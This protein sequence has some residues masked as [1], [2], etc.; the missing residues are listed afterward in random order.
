MT[1]LKSKALIAGFTEAKRIGVQ[2]DLNVLL[3]ALGMK[4]RE[5]RYKPDSTV[6]SVLVKADFTEGPA[7][8]VAWFT[9]GTADITFH[10]GEFMRLHPD[11]TPEQL[12]SSLQNSPNAMRMLASA[13]NMPSSISK[14]DFKIAREIAGLLIHE[15]GHALF[16]TWADIKISAK[17]SVIHT[18]VLFEEG[19][20][21][22]RVVDRRNE[23]QPKF[24]VK[25]Y[26]RSLARLLLG[27][28]DLTFPNMHSMLGTWSLVKSR[29]LA[30]TLSMDEFAPIDN[31]VRSHVGDELM[32]MLSDIYEE[33]MTVKAPKDLDR[34]MELAT[35][36]EDLITEASGEEPGV[37][38]HGTGCSHLVEE[39][40]GEE[41][42]GGEGEEGD[43]G[44]EESDGKSESGKSG[45]E[46]GKGGPGEPGSD[47]PNTD[48]KPVKEEDEGEFVDVETLPIVEGEANTS[49]LG[50]DA[51]AAVRK[52]VVGLVE[53]AEWEKPMIDSDLT[54][55]RD[56]A[57]TFL[58]RPNYSSGRWVVR[59]PTSIE[60]TAANKLA[61]HLE[62]LMVPTIGQ[63]KVLTE[64]PTG[65]LK[66]R[67]AVR[68]SAERSQGRMSTAKPW[69]DKR[70][71]HTLGA[72]AI[73]GIATDTSGSM[74]WAQAMVASAA[75]IIGHAGHRINAKTA[76]VTFGSAV[77]AVLAPGEVPSV[78]RERAADGGTEELDQALA[79][80]D[81]ALGLTSNPGAAKVL[82]IISDNEL[83]KPFEH[84][85]REAWLEKLSKAG[86]TIIW[87]DQAK[88]NVPHTTS[89]SFEWTSISRE[90]LPLKL[91]ETISKALDKAMGRGYA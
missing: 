10:V 82:V 64:K 31:A 18:M 19:R 50:P 45:G 37:G 35:E 77:E 57:N 85:K 44:G 76:A 67:E 1:A 84:A 6:A 51:K 9:P 81:A 24:R 14:A 80:L 60:V 52:A 21:E 87:V 43:E 48:P 78:V 38:G 8:A 86:V 58:K 28:L 72:P 91:V 40:E 22:K 39:E 56:G 88:R 41:G 4:T 89:V 5:D 47:K 68:R 33:A 36:W 13:P 83:V 59:K 63:T 23:H 69:I 3:G 65:R 27:E 61:S 30:G 26:L 17:P 49:A 66:S 32:D 34:L 46:G 16:S 79:A 15:G 90:L 53:D 25:E 42:E 70:R 7:P 2:A 73:V 12:I 29:A 55:L 11:L 71:K 54:S 20:I 62:T 75:Y 74:A